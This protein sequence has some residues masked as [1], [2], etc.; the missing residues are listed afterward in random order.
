MAIDVGVLAEQPRE[1]VYLQH[2][3]GVIV[4][5]PTGAGK[6]WRVACQRVWDAPG[7]V[8]AT[9]TKADLVA[10]TF[11]TCAERGTVAVF[12][13]EG[14]TGWPYSLRWSILAGCDDPDTAIRRADAL[15]RAMPLEGTRNGAYFEQKAAT[16]VRCYL[17][18]A[19]LAEYSIRDVRVWVSA[20]TNRTVID[21]LTTALPDWATELEQILGSASESTDD[22]L[23]AAARLLE[24]LAS[25]KLLAA[26]DVPVEESFDIASFVL[27]GANTLYLV[28]RG[29]TRSMAPFVAALAAEVHHIADRA[30]QYRP[31][32]RLD[33]PIRLVLDEMNNIAPIPDLPMIMTDSGGKGISVWAFAHNQDQNEL[34][35]G[36]EGGRVLAQSA[37]AMLILPGLRGVDELSALSRLLGERRRW[38]ATLHEGSR[39]YT[40]HDDTVLR[41]D[42]IRELDTDHALLIYRNAPAIL[43]RLPSVWDVPHWRHAVTESTAAFDQIITRRAVRH[44]SR[45][46]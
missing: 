22:V 38:E 23:A 6:T 8:L 42:E 15:A 2:R 32:N 4:H 24:P 7:F 1:H 37:P 11:T 13:P 20:R 29:N 16:L 9:T 14:L 35:W 43:L 25:P 40:L 10:A 18:A 27:S 12:D 36:T 39:S 3:D 45:K 41:T 34:R 26:V 30:S 28:S 17:H 21:I 33:P 44:H 31:G 19:A 5:G 46:E